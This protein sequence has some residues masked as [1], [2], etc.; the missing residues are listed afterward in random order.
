MQFISFLRII[1]PVNLFI[2][3]FTQYMVRYAFLYPAYKYVGFPLQLNEWVFALFSLAFVLM[4]AGGYIINDYYDVEIDKVNKPGKVIIGEKIK[5]SHALIAYWVLSIAGLLIGSWSS[6]KAGLPALSSVFFIYMSGLW[7]YSNTLKYEFI[8]GNLVVAFFLGL[9][10]FCSGIIELYADIKNPGFE[11]SGLNFTYLLYWII[12][13]SVFAF[14]STLAREIVKDIED[15]EGDAA[16]GCRTLP[17]VMGKEAAR[18]IVQFLLMLIVFLLAYL[19]YQQWK[20]DD[21]KSILYFTFLIQLPLISIIVMM[22]KASVPKD[23]H[24]L[25]NWIKLLMVSGISYL[26]VFAYACLHP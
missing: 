22:N 14:I 19:Q 18:R 11:Q 2:I 3:V 1:R 23:Y 24:R 26:F 12:G 15:M 25:S 5:P 10:P 20:V 7:Y 4:A 16:Q 13:I 17:I 6:Y 21:M 8:L 9:V